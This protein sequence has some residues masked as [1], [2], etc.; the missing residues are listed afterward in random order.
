MFLHYHGEYGARLNRTESVH[1][2]QTPRERSILFE[3]LNIMFFYM[4]QIYMQKF[5]QISVDGLT[6]ATPW[7]EFRDQMRKGWEATTTPVC[8][9]IHDPRSV[10][11]SRR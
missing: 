7:N 3:A 2:E 10:L 1:Y 8:N 9:A 11:I 4:P 5:D 6:N